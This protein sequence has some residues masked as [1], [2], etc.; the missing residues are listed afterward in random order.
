[1]SS[2]NITDKTELKNRVRALTGYEDEPDELPDSVLD[3]LITVAQQEVELATGS[4]NWFS[5]NG[6]GLA[7][8]ATTCI[9]SKE[10]IENY[11]M[12]E[13][14]LGDEVIDVSG[15]ADEDA[16]QFQSW[17]ELAK[18]GI[19][20]HTTPSQSSDLLSNTADYI[21]G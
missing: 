14:E 13:W 8:L 6:L 17:N 15:V 3:T 16:V 20:S 18:K 10:R 9:R 12:S 1:M 5:D 4:T 7:L 19:K 11:S 2:H 21:G